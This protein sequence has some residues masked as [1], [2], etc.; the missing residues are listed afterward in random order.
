MTTPVVFAG[1]SELFEVALVIVRLL[2]HLFRVAIV[3]ELVDA[4][5]SGASTS[6]CGG[7]SPP[8]RTKHRRKCT[9]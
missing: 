6:S 1:L 2:W 5:V 9:A 8:D 4:L 7:S 3:A